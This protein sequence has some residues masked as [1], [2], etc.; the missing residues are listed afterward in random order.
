MNTHILIAHIQEFLELDAAIRERAERPLLLEVGSHLGVSYACVSLSTARS[1]F[2]PSPHSISGTYHGE[3]SKLFWAGYKGWSE[4]ESSGL[5]LTYGN[6]CTWYCIAHLFHSNPLGIKVSYQNLSD[7]IHES[8]HCGL[9]VCNDSSHMLDVDGRMIVDNRCQG[10][11]T[12]SAC[13]HSVIC[14]C[15]TPQNRPTHLIEKYIVLYFET[16]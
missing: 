8:S 2:Q 11:I 10:T 14:G 6:L 12:Y 4:N 15:R 3:S 16:K 7:R 13:S 5:W 9:K 1:P